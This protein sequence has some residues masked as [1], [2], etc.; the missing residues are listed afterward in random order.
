MN[1]IYQGKAPKLLNPK[2]FKMTAFLEHKKT[3]VGKLR[4]MNLIHNIT[5]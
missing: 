2:K 4:S 3:L 5:K 1:N